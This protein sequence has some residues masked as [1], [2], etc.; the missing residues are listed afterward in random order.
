MTAWP[1]LLGPALVLPP[2]GQRLALAVAHRLPRWRRLLS[3]AWVVASIALWGSLALSV[4]ARAPE[5]GGRAVVLILMAGLLWVEGWTLHALTRRR[6]L[7]AGS[8]RADLGLDGPPAAPPRPDAIPWPGEVADALLDRIRQCDQVPVER[9][10]TPREAIVFAEIRQ[11]VG[12]VLELMRRS[13]RSRIPVAS[14]GSLD[15]ILGVAHAKDLVPLVP[16]GGR[17]EVLRRH[18]R[19]WLR[20]PRGQSIAGLLEDFRSARVHIGIVGD[21]MGRT[22]G[23]VTLGDI[24]RFLAGAAP[25]RQE[26]P[27]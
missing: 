14:A 20:V 7:E 1:W 8:A 18:L 22:L 9:I 5:W 6:S 17:D 11:P 15:Q 26:K 4:H 27:R 13:G 10:M 21:S 23:L 16:A 19:R 25:G 3:A 2:L 24:F 12:E